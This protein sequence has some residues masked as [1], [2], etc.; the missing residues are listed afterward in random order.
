V[1]VRGAVICALLVLAAASPATVESSTHPRGRGWVH[2]RDAAR[3]FAARELAAGA[4]AITPRRPSASPLFGNPGPSPLGIIAWTAGGI[5]V[6]ATESNQFNP[7]VASVDNGSVIAA[8][9]DDRRA[10]GNA[11]DVYAMKINGDG[12][13]A[14]PEDGVALSVT[15]S[16]MLETVAMPDGAGGAFVIFGSTD[17]AAYSDVFA[18]HVTASGAI[19]SGWPANGLGVAPGG[20][21]GYG[22]VPTND[23]S[24]LM[25]WNDLAGQLRLLRLTGSGGLASGWTAAGLP[26][27]RPGLE[28]SIEAVPDGAGGVY[29]VWAQSDSV[30]LTL[31]AAGGG[32]APG[33]SAAGTV[34]VS[35]TTLDFGLG[36]ALLKG[37]DVMVFWSDIRSFTGLEIYAMR[38]TSAGAPEPGWPATGVAAVAGPG[39]H[40][41]PEAVPDGVGGALVVCHAG[42]DSVVAQR[43]TGAG[44]LS[45]G[46]PAGGVTLARHSGKAASAPIA[47]GLDGVLIAWNAVKN[48]EDDIFA[49]R[50]SGGGAV[51]SGWPN[52]GQ[53]VCD[54]SGAQYITGIVPDGSSGLIAVWE[55]GRTFPQ[56]LYAARVQSDGVVGALAALVSASAEPGLVRLHWFSPEGPAFEAGL[57]RAAGE[58]AFVEIARVG[59][60][61]GHIRYEDRDVVAGETYHYRLAIFEGGAVRYLGAVSLRIPVPEGPRLTLA[62]FLPNP[63][64]GSPRL[65]YTLPT[66]ERARIEVLD[67]AGRR[68]LERELDSAP[69]E[70]VVAF[71]GFA[72]GPGVYVLR[73]TQG[74]RSV[75]TR[76]A[77]VR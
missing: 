51:P 47:D 16:V 24:L 73:L 63:S 57:E 64:V 5:P 36:G 2:S 26:V 19:A 42:S 44:A 21:S 22:A 67:T 59:A 20:A 50:V 10:P 48:L 58:G 66:A 40:V 33:W 7:S 61:A 27:G 43:M 75:M 71:E 41:L 14:W 46:W 32:F 77:V 74:T 29:M 28:G 69:G 65:A 76:A 13:R 12:V 72:L 56:R 35:S 15:D 70:H 68:V 54:S 6:C 37:G 31:V 45:F 25:G 1:R 60:E 34:V 49:Q 30:M 39:F 17:G 55:D 9:I 52:G 53:T 23:G 38:Y 4:S 62:G 8:W 18:Q 11:Y 3:S